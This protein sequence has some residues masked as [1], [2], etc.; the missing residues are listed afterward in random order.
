MRIL[1]GHTGPVYD[2]KFLP[3]SESGQESRHVLSASR[4]GTVRLFDLALGGANTYVYRGHSRAVWKVSVSGTGWGFAT[5][6]LDCT[7][8]VFDFE[9]PF[10]VRLLAADMDSVD[11]VVWA[12]NGKYLATG[13]ADGTVRLW[14]VVQA[15]PVRLFSGFENGRG[16][17]A[18]SFSPD[19]KYLACA[20]ENRSFATSEKAA[21]A[22][23]SQWL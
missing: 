10:P 5:G 13:S 6:S 11:A 18:L 2:L 9:R 3:P 20:A 16:V 23:V 21:A 15:T 1:R 7:A 4:D 8:R 14:D 19:G 12:P 17:D 22:L